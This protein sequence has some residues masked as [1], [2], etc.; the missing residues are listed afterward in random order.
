VAGG[1][2]SWLQ[3]QLQ[4]VLV[5]VGAFSI[6]AAMVRMVWTSRAEPAREMLAGLLRL[7]VIS[8]AG[9]AGI[10][11]LLA[12]GDAFSSAILNAA[13]PNGGN[14]GHL[15]VLGAEVIPESGLLV[16]LALIA[17]LASLIQIFLL[18]AR[19][20]LVVVLG[21]TW[22]LSAAASSTP[23]GGA[24]FKKTTAW[25]LA[26][27]LFKPVASVIYAAALRLTLSKSSGGL[28]TVEGVMLFAM[29]ILALPALMRFAVP[30]VSA[31]GGISAGKAAAGA[32]VLA[33]GAIATTGALGAGL[34]RGSAAAGGSSGGSPGGGQ[35]PTG[36]APTGGASTPPGGPTPTGAGGA[37]ANPGTTAAQQTAATPGVSTGPPAGAALATAHAAR[38][39]ANAIPK[40]TGES[41]SS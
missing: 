3:A 14:F 9:L 12:A 24:W 8:G 32:A 18:I 28:E 39:V 5:F 27:I 26:F 40:T 13:T 38:G 20:G 36:A 33:T 25:L 11:I 7:V 21:G 23:A 2:T 6:I 37:S 10:D 30:A 17:I 41:Q 29:A 19:G 16:I 22:P 1:T 31:V 35:P 15:V 4:P 34:A